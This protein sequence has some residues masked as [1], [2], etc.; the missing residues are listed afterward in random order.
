MGHHASPLVPMTEPVSRATH[1]MSSDGNRRIS[2]ARE[3]S[4]GLGIP[5]T[6][7][8]GPAAHDRPATSTT[9]K[10]A[11][12]DPHQDPSR[13]R[14]RPRSRSS[15]PACRSGQRADAAGEAGLEPPRGRLERQAPRS[16]HRVR[17]ERREDRQ[18]L[19]P[20]RRGEPRP[21]QG[22]VQR[23]PRH[24]VDAVQAA[25]R[26]PSRSSRS[27]RGRT[28]PSPATSRARG[29]Y[30]LQLDEKTKGDWDTIRRFSFSYPSFSISPL[31][32]G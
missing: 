25:A 21:R 10:G 18:R 1:R 16:V 17:R 26:S 28:S 3:S 22:A 4:S 29:K 13:S 19:P 23:R 30:V 31:P 11:D 12:D 2:S 20:R 6:R 27:R 7:P 24:A 15:R 32:L 14:P 8:S 5:G 9:H